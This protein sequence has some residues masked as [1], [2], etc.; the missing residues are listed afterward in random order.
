M[1]KLHPNVAVASFQSFVDEFFKAAPKQVKRYTQYIFDFLLVAA[2][3]EEGNNQQDKSSQLAISMEEIDFNLVMMQ[4]AS[5]HFSSVKKIA[6][7]HDK[8]FKKEK[9]QEASNIIVPWSKN[10]LVQNPVN[11]LEYSE[12]S[13]KVDILHSSMSNACASIKE[14]Q[15]NPVDVAHTPWA[16]N[17][18]IHTM[19]IQ[20]P[21]VTMANQA[22]SLANNGTTVGSQNPSGTIQTS[23]NIPNLAPMQGWYNL[24]QCKDGQQINLYWATHG[25]QYMGQCLIRKTQTTGTHIIQDL[26]QHNRQ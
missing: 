17:H 16:S 15:Q 11:S 9:M 26:S 10:P 4:W 20:N 14:G 24:D 2:G 13:N 3:S 23:N 19:G 8:Q 5:T 6:S 18:A 21:P 1:N 22:Y 25:H 7:Q 12:N